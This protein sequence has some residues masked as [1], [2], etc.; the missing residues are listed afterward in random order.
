MPKRTY[1]TVAT[2]G[3]FDHLHAGHERLLEKSFEVGDHVVIGLTSDDFVR[4]EGKSP[5]LT[6]SQ[7]KRELVGYLEETFPGRRYTIS[8]LDDYFG[9]GIADSKVEALVASPETGKRIAFANQLRAKEGFPPLDLVLVD[10]VLSKDG[11][12]VSS[13][14]IRKGEIDRGGRV[15]SSKRRTGRPPE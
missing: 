11:R 7:R 10:W 5:D 6:Y 3:T 8:K 13:T 1:S 9:P 15:L 4:R 14:R 2:G 12:P